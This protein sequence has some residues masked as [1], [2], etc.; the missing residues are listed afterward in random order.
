MQNFL[1]G[2]L[3]N[4]TGGANMPT[5]SLLGQYYDPAAMRRYQMKHMLLGLGAGLL[6][7]KGIGRGAALA[8]AAAANAGSQYRDNAMDAYRIKSQQDQQAKA[9]NR[10]Q[11]Q[12]DWQQKQAEAEA[13]R[14]AKAD[15][16]RMTE[17]GWKVEDRENPPPL[18][19]TDDIREYNFAKQQ[20]FPGTFQ[21]WMIAGKKAGATNVNVGGGGSD[22]DIFTT[23]KEQSDAAKA[24]Q[25]GLSSLSQAQQA[26]PGA[27]TGAA[28]D[29]RLGLQKIGALLGVA[30]TNSIVDTET[31]RSAI[32]PQVAA[33]LKA[34]VG[35]TQ[36]SNADREFAEKAAAGSIQLDKGSIERLMNI[37]QAA[38]SEAIRGF[39]STLDKVYPDGQ[40]FDRER[41]LFGV[42]NVA[43]RYASPIGPGEPQQGAFPRPEAGAPIDPVNPR[44]GD[45]VLG[46]RFKG[47][48]RRDPNNWEKVQ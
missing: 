35:S 39:N 12:W 45:V 27:I 41:A 40:G 20:G 31:F 8:A 43:K 32:A 18:S 24:A 46:Y 14:Q 26:L 30:D 19:P 3:G 17:F 1:N 10:W 9:D 36:I 28:A 33:M 29:Q 34:T 38:N 15:A 48:D 44:P 7:E 23:T 37:M 11:M 22:K 5:D 25:R 13:K 21:D 16:M 4:V 47:G 2:L 6:T 42:P